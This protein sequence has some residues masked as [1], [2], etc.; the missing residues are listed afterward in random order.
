MQRSHRPRLLSRASTRAYPALSPYLVPRGP[1]HAVR[2]RH[3]ALVGAQRIGMGAQPQ[4]EPDHETSSSARGT[5]TGADGKRTWFVMPSGSWSNPTTYTGTLYATSG[6]AFTGPFDPSLVTIDAVG[7][8][9]L[10]S[11]MRT[12]PR[13]PTA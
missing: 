5:R 9:T 8:G 11:A 12:T 3:L 13:G 6:P 2:R 10:S 7:T 1:A 4:P